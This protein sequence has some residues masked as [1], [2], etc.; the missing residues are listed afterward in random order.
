MA[1]RRTTPAM[2]TKAIDAA[3]SRGLPVSAIEVHSGGMV[4]VIIQNQ[5]ADVRDDKDLSCDT[6]FEVGCD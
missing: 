1:N 5:P 3:K 2:I 6:I 4:R